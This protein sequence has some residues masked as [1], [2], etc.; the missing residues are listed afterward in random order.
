MLKQSLERQVEEHTLSNSK[1]PATTQRAVT[2]VE[3][4]DKIKQSEMRLIFLLFIFYAEGCI[5]S[6]TQMSQYGNFSSCDTLVIT[7]L[8]LRDMNIT[9][10]ANSITIQACW[11]LQSINLII[12]TEAPVILQFINNTFLSSYRIYLNSSTYLYLS[13][14]PYPQKFQLWPNYLVSSL[15]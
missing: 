2:V 15:S 1:P 10:S 5:N 4:K 13:Q 8:P 7:D 9:T 14:V 6:V 11:Q 3:S 12:E